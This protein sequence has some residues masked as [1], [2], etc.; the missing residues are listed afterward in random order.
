MAY[1][2]KKVEFKCLVKIK[3]LSLF[4]NATWKDIGYGNLVS[5]WKYWRASDL[6]GT[7]P[8]QLQ[9]EKDWNLEFVDTCEYVW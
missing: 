1:F 2:W 6:G 4:Y 8:E 3:V 7:G 5:S 9:Y